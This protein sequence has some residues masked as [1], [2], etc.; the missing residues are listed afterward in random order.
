MGRVAIVTGGVTGIGAATCM[1][2]KSAGYQ[3]AA[4]YFGNSAEAQKFSDETAISI[5]EWNVA[6]FDA[7]QKGVEQV[8]GALG[9]IDILINNAGITQDVSLHKMSKQ[10][11]QS[12][13][14]IDLGG[15]FNMCR[16]VIGPM[17]DRRFGR[18][19]NISSINGLAGQ[20]GQTNYSAAKAGVIGFT[21]ALALEGAARGI[22]VNAI[23]PGYTDTAMVSAVRPDI[24]KS[25]IASVPAG[26]LAKPEEI[27]R[28]AAFLVA[29]GSGFITG[30]TLSINGGKYMA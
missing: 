28:A 26:R 7:C 27:A 11:W 2:L 5:F 17:R 16:W 19:V 8:A 29:D 3:V 12:V 10:Q 1:A 6:D 14:D 18:I 23:A 20:F 13:I 15:C 4:N 9:P 25:I 22:T 30:A 21:K 24:L